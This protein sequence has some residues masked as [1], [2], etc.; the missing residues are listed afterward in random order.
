MRSTNA[1]G[2]KKAIGSISRLDA[3]PQRQQNV[4]CVTRPRGIV[5]E[6]A[7]YDNCG[8]ASALPFCRM[9]KL[10]RSRSAAFDGRSNPSWQAY[11]DE[12]S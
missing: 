2:Q 8:G 4:C 3:S 11:P 9:R 5:V 10:E 12:L 1:F 6:T 7:G